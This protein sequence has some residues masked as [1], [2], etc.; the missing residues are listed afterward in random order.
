MARITVE[1][2]IEKVPNRFQLVQMASVR[3][4]QLKRGSNSLVSGEG[5]K[6]VVAALREIAAGHVTPGEVVV[7]TEGEDEIVSNLPDEAVID[8]AVSDEEETPADGPRDT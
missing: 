6:V 4:K 3:A 1:D 7:E 8:T 5:N 2:C